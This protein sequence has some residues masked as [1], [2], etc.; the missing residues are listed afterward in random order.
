GSGTLDAGPLEK[1]TV[2]ESSAAVPSAP[3]SMVRSSS[4]PN[5]PELGKSVES[6]SSEL[7]SIPNTSR[8]SPVVEQAS[9]SPPAKDPLGHKSRMPVAT[10]SPVTVG[11]VRPR[12]APISVSD[13]VKPTNSSNTSPAAAAVD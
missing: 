8:L 13:A 10:P 9:G 7:S 2:T 3:P 11:G 4:T 5:T 12:D 1:P 6:A